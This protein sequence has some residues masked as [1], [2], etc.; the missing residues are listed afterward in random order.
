[1]FVTPLGSFNRLILNPVT[2]TLSL[3][4][5]EVPFFDPEDEVED[6][7]VEDF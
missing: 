7:L 5:E 4:S 1:M 2:L 6:E 3:V